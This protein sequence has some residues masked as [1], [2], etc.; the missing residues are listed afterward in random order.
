MVPEDVE[1]LLR[2]PSPDDERDRA[3]LVAHTIARLSYGAR[4]GDYARVGALDPDPELAAARY[5][6]EQLAGD[7]VDRAAE[8]AVRRL[9]ALSEPL[10]ELYEYQPD[11]L[12]QQLIAATLLRAVYAERQLFEVMVGFWSDHFNIDLSKG[13]CRWLL[14]AHDRDV[15]RAHAVGRFPALLRAVVL[16]P[17]MLWYLDGRANR[18]AS[19]DEK[20]NE[21]YARELLEL[22]ALGANGGYDQADVTEV[23]RALSGWSV[24]SK[25]ASHFG[26]GAVEFTA[27]NHDD[28]EKQ[29]LGHTLSPGGGRQDV[30][31]VLDIVTAHPSC[32]HFIATKLCRRFIDDDPPL[33]A[34]C[35][36]TSTFSATRGDIAACLRTVFATDAFRNA[37]ASRLK[38]PFHFVASALRVTGASTDGGPGV[39]QWL[40]RM[41]HRRCIRSCCPHSPHQRFSVP[42]LGLVSCDTRSR[43]RTSTERLVH[44][45]IRARSSWSSSA[46]APMG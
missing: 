1:A 19:S 5:V 14:P 25:V 43:R 21:N 8:R 42:D 44:R 4:P 30:Q 15:I 28:G 40:E 11:I 29:V 38:R 16:S 37:R 36:V 23:A 10:G 24:R 20:P 3:D 18:R 6:N 12:R 33:A 39:T 7:R 46:E 41:G 27:A 9:E 26:I 34:V 13:D 45:K 22:H 17:A 31:N 2:N 32:A 35:A